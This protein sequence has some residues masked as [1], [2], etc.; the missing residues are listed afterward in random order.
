MDY[1]DVLWNQLLGVNQ[2]TFSSRSNSGVGWEGEGKGTVAIAA[3]QDT[4]IYTENGHWT[5]AG[6]RELKFHNSFRW[7][8]QGFLVRLEHLRF[9]PNQAVFLFDLSAGEDGIWRDLQ[10]H[11]CNLDFYSASLQT[12]T[13]GYDLRW[14]VQGANRD[15]VMEYRYF[16]SG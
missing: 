15:E 3:T 4:L 13:S 11:T 7:T 8:R 9:G 12:S 5:Q 14:R 6:G 1:A 2:F 10:P 16:H